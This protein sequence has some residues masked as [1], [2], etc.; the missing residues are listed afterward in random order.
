MVLVAVRRQSL[1]REVTRILCRY[2]VDAPLHEGDRLPGQR[3]LADYLQ[4]SR[5]VVR[6]ALSFLEARGIIIIRAGDGVVVHNAALADIE[7]VPDFPEPEDL[8]TRD[9]FEF[10]SVLY[11]GLPELICARATDEDIERLQQLLSTMEAKLR[12]GKTI[13]SEVQ[14]FIWQLA[15]LSRNAIVLGLRPLRSE[16][17]RRGL[18]AQS[19]IIGKPTPMALHHLANHREMVAAI[20]ARDPERLRRIFREELPMPA[21][22]PSP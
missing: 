22:T 14:E 18:L 13:L 7:A 16:V 12:L 15:A 10:R 19:S 1:R 3:D 20:S 5:T 9:L 2:I 11:L 21:D 17:D 8:P 6:E 4:V